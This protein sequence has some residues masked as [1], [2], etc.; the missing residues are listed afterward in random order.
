MCGV[1]VKRQGREKAILAERIGEAQCGGQ[2]RTKYNDIY[3]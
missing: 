3:V 2:N 1:I